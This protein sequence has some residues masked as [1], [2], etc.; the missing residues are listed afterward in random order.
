MS[1]SFSV[2]VFLYSL[3]SL[4]FGKAKVG[5]DFLCGFR[6]FVYCVGIFCRERG[7]FAVC[8]LFLV[9]F[10]VFVFLIAVVFSLLFS[11]APYFPCHY[12]N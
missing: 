8:C 12:R 1:S 3:N 11:K 9:W 4:I 6:C 7:R 10:F 5:G 2:K